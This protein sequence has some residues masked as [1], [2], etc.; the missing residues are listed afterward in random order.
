M[1]KGCMKAGMRQIQ[2]K[3]SC[4]QKRLHPDRPMVS[5]AILFLILICCL[6]AELIMTKDP[7]YLDLEHSNTAPCREFLFGTDTLGRDIFSMIW[8]GGRISLWIGI[9]AAL[10]SA[11]LAVVI[12]TVS[13]SAPLWVDA[14]LMRLTEILLSVPGMLSVILLQAAFGQANAGSIAF[15]IGATSWMSMAKM[16]RTEVRQIRNQEYI[17]AAKC[18]GGS[19]FYVLWR[20]LAPNFLPSIMFMAVMNIRSAIASEAALS[21]MGIGLPIETVSWGSMLS[22]AEKALLGSSWWVVLF[23][24]GFLTVTLLCITNIGNDIRKN[25]TLRIQ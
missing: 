4:S 3:V 7:A 6:F 14:F 17:I 15:A 11:V 25:K 24:G 5:A 16:V 22:L 20:H 8:Y 9:E 12:G 13:G 10:I 23:P 18:M 2:Q 19:F 1:K 21:F